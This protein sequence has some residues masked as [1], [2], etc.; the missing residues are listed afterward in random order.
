MLVKDNYPYTLAVPQ[1][2]ELGVGILS[3]LIKQAR[4]SVEEFNR[5]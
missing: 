3:K 4:L 5:L 1:H 2:K